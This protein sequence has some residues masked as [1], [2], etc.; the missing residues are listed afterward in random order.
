MLSATI[1][2][3]THCHVTLRPQAAG[4]VFCT[5]DFARTV[6]LPLA[7]RFDTT[8]PLV[9]HKAVYNRIVR[10]FNRGQPPPVEVRTCSDASPGSGVGS[11]STLVV[12]VVQAYAA[13]IQLPLGEHDVAHLAYEIERVDC[14]MA[15]GRQDQFAA[16]FGRSNFIE[17]GAN[18]RVVVKPLHIIESQIAATQGGAGNDAVEAMYAIERAAT[19]MRRPCWRAASR[20]RSTSWAPA[21]TPRSARRPASRTRTSTRSR[22]RQRRQAHRA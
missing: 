18:D 4:V 5:D 20:P 11:S 13:L 10:D 8:E 1:S 7:P 6:E 9:L 22:P 19:E 12:A 17:F 14:A 3:F 15:S 21:G 2:L 16:A